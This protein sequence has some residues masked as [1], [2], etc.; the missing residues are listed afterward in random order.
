MTEITHK[1]LLKEN[2]QDIEVNAVY[3][4]KKQGYYCDIDARVTE[5]ESKM[6][7]RLQNEE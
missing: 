2:D 5:K 6:D 7:E 4:S 3:G 1:Q